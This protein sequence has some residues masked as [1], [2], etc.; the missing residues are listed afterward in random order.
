M[1]IHAQVEITS[2]PDFAAAASS[3]EASYHTVLLNGL[4]ILQPS[5]EACHPA[6][7]QDW[8]IDCGQKRDKKFR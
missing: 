3:T 7:C 1:N 2:T 5:G 6:S 8:V 4:A